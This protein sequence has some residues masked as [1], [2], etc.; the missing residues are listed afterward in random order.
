M[1]CPK[2]GAE[3]EQPDDTI[4]QSLV[5][6]LADAKE[7]LNLA[8][9]GGLILLYDI[10]RALGWNEKTSLS[11]LGDGVRRVR[12]AL[13]TWDTPTEMGLE[14]LALAVKARVKELEQVTQSQNER[15]T[16][17]LEQLEELHDESDL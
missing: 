11:I 8:N 17:L 15:I 13:Q 3:M 12:R 5:S 1:N 10:R 16:E 7:R 4:R 2:C 6:E 9:A 14:E